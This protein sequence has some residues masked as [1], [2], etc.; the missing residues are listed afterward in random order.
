M[1]LIYIH[2]LA[3]YRLIEDR[4]NE[5]MHYRP[6]PYFAGADRHPGRVRRGVGRMLVGAGQRLL[7][8]EGIAR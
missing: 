5:R 7:R 6:T 8:A 4:L 3:A 2:Q 1:D